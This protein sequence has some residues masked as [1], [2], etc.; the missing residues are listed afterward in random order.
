[1]ANIKPAC[2]L[3]YIFNSSL[4]DI[5][6]LPAANYTDCSC[7][8][9]KRPKSSHDTVPLRYPICKVE[10]SREPS[11]VTPLA[12]STASLSPLVGAK[13]PNLLIL[14]GTRP[15]LAPLVI[16]ESSL[17]PLVSSTQ[18]IRVI[19]PSN[20]SSL[21]DDQSGPTPL[22]STPSA[23]TPLVALTPV[24]GKPVTSV[25]FNPTLKRSNHFL[26]HLSQ[27]TGKRSAIVRVESRSLRNPSTSP[28]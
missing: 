1:M 5:S 12:S 14:L 9:Q 26:R 15:G 17:T 25:L 27:R 21:D 13:Q 20:Q 2:L 18:P 28:R 23:G 6:K 16:S 10:G 19:S 4:L 7:V 3:L 22:V 11:C 24:S 8:R